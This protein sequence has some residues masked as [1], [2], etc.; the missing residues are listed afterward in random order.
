MRT[1]GM[2]RVIFTALLIL[3]TT[4]G[5]GVAQYPIEPGTSAGGYTPAGSN[6]PAG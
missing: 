1:R 5:T 4:V 3:L 6:T 2:T